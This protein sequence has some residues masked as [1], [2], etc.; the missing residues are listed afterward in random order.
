MGAEDLGAGVAENRQGSF[1]QA[2]G[3]CPAGKMETY[4]QRAEDHPLQ[5]KPSA[6]LGMPGQGVREASVRVRYVSREV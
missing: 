2:R 1:Q 5:Y 4:H 6:A 3:L